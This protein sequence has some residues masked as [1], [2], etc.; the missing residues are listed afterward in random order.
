VRWTTP[1]A[2]RSGRNAEII[3]GDVA[4]RLIDIKAQEGGDEPS[5][6][7]EPASS[8]RFKSGVLNLSYVPA[9]D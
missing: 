6:P 4:R 9:K 1:C 5:I 8:H 2:R 3:N 7:L